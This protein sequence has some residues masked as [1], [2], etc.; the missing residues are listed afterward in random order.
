MN[1]RSGLALSICAARCL[2]KRKCLPSFFGRLTPPPAALPRSPPGYEK[3]IRSPELQGQGR[4][5]RR[6]SAP[7][8]QVTDRQFSQIL[9][10]YFKYFSENQTF[11]QRK[12]SA[13]HQCFLDYR[14]QKG[15]RPLWTLLCELFLC[16][17]LIIKQIGFC[18]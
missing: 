2:R 15:N 1:R 4:Q 6:W 18:L 16:L 14:K 8:W 7:R 11:S 12:G 17:P 9:L 3:P 10:L 13:V 5:D